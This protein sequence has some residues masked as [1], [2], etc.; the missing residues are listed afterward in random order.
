ME[1]NKLFN[2]GLPSP[3]LAQFGRILRAEFRPLFIARTMFVIQGK[4]IDALIRDI[5]LP[6][7]TD[8][9]STAARIVIEAA[10]DH[11]SVDVKPL[12]R[13]SLVAK[14]ISIVVKKTYLYYPAEESKDRTIQELLTIMLQIQDTETFLSF[15]ERTVCSMTLNVLPFKMR[16]PV[17]P[18]GREEVHR[19][20]LV[21]SLDI[22]LADRHWS[23]WFDEWNVRSQEKL[24]RWPCRFLPEDTHRFLSE[25]T[26]REILG[27]GMELLYDRRGPRTPINFLKIGEQ[28]QE[29]LKQLPWSEDVKAG[30]NPGKEEQL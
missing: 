5:I 13:I 21:R 23:S 28:C 10:K 8:I 26:Q 30:E 29:Q 16:F 25:E 7:D 14:D 20:K 22:G 2:I 17:E 6:P 11:F 3:G 1:R 19:T 4:D 12:L 9:Q 15:V 18:E 27:T 24:R